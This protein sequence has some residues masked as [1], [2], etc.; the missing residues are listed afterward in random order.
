MPILV[1]EENSKELGL[2]SI[3]YFTKTVLSLQIA[4][5]KIKMMMMMMTMTIMIMI[6]MIIVIIRAHSFPRQNLTNSAA[7]RGYTVKFPRLD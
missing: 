1:V 4:L 2:Q 5:I 6:I 3:I 7:H